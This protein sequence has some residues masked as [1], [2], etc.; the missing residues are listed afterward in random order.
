M[1]THVC[2]LRAEL[3]RDAG[4]NFIDA[5]MDELREVHLGIPHPNPDSPRPSE[6]LQAAYNQA[7]DAP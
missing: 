4:P 3:L 1:A 2:A 6:Q 5:L 7:I